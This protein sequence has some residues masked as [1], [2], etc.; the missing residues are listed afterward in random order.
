MQKIRGLLRL[1]TAAQIILA[2]ILCG[3]AKS[4]KAAEQRESVTGIAFRA[5]AS[6]MVLAWPSTPL[7]SFAVLWRSNST[8]ETPWATLTNLIAASAKGLTE[9]HDRGALLR[10]PGLKTNADFADLYRVIVIPD[11]WADMKGAI[12]E[13]GPNNPG[14]DFL[15]FY[16]GTDKMDY[17]KPEVQ[18]FVDGQ[19]DPEDSG[20]VDILRVNRGT[21]E[22]PQWIYATGIWFAHDRL[23]EGEHVLQLRSLCRL[24][25]L[26]ERGQSITLT[27]K[28]VRVKIK[29]SQKHS[30]WNQ[31][32]GKEFIRS[33]PSPEQYNNS[34]TQDDNPLEQKLTTRPLD[35]QQP[36][37]ATQ[38]HM[39]L[40]LDQENPMVQITPE[41][42]NAVVKAVLP[43]FSET[44]KRLNLPISEPIKTSDVAQV[45]IPP[46]KNIKASVLLKNGWIFNFGA[47]YVRSVVSPS[48]YYRLKDPDKIPEF[49]GAVKITEAEAIQTARET[50]SKLN[51]PLDAVFADQN[52][53]VTPPVKVGTNAVPRF[54]VEWL[55]PRGGNAVADIEVNGQN[56]NVE[57]VFLALHKNLEQ[58]DPNLHMAAPPKAPAGEFDAHIPPPISLAY[59]EK[60]ISIV[61]NAIDA[62][63]A[64]L[65]LPVRR[66]L[67]TN[68][69]ARIQMFNNGGWP[70]CEV[71]LT[72][73][74]RFI[75]RH[76]MVNGFYAPDNFFNSDR[77]TIR[78]SEFTGK[79][80][81]SEAQAVKLVEKE[82]AKLNYQT[83]DLHMNFAPHG[84]F[85][86]GDFKKIV[87]RYFFEW[88]FENPSHDDLQ[89]KIEAEVDAD[90]G[91][92]KSL[93]YDDKAYWNERPEIDI[94]IS[95]PWPEKRDF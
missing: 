73:G 7:E 89:S 46:L 49:Y 50:L 81:M 56:R 74:W 53:R 20:D 4:L 65:S 39:V 12:L 17:L 16:F 75:Y 62:Y 58:P 23:S 54:R 76:T 10:T 94:P 44:A 85:A 21:M 63:G 2:V 29:N 38:N 14:E 25:Y 40:Q 84:I 30:W 1:A 57:R 37:P 32:L 36:K 64:K 51:I 35:L 9:F 18:L 88:R 45:G 90:R 11:F 60:L 13:G 43:Y 24:D 6:D 41:Y 22:K 55:D 15:P 66:P 8:I 48:S 70:H 79:W 72:N 78:M 77:R 28:P 91:V 33:R 68:S 82:I 19:D 31:R 67:T 26:M 69:V 27:N 93:Y 47:G 71:E 92:L 83:N 80:N 52:P 86:S 95:A 61:L 34:K 59:A 87:P 42:S 3:F 5:Q